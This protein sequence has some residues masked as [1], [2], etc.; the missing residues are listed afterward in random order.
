MVSRLACMRAVPATK[1]DLVG[2]RARAEGCGVIIKHFI[3]DEWICECSP[4]ETP[5]EC[6]AAF[7]AFLKLPYDEQQERFHE[8]WLT[9]RLDEANAAVQFVLDLIPRPTALSRADFRIPKLKR[10]RP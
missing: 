8:A 7:M 1:R 10:W 2:V 6:Q 5:E 9:T 3:D 4:G